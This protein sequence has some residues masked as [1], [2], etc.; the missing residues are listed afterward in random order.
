MVDTQQMVRKIWY[1]TYII[2]NKVITRLYAE[3]QLH[4]DTLI[5]RHHI[6]YVISTLDMTKLTTL[7]RL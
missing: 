2:K 5:L 7:L 6:Y 3:K 1:A 4:I